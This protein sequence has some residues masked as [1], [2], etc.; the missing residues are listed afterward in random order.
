M[1]ETTRVRVIYSGEVQG[2]GFRFAARS[3]AANTSITGYVQN[4]SDGTVLV[5]A[6]GS[7]ERLNIFLKDLRREMSAYISDATV[8]WQ[9]PS[10]EFDSFDIRF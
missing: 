7:R 10:Y 5:V 6:E 2:V 8:D 3:V 4:L 1:D 9:D